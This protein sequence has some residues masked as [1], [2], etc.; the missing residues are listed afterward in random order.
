MDSKQQEKAADLSSNMR[1]IYV[2]KYQEAQDAYF[3]S[4][5][6]TPY[7]SSVYHGLISR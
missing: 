1:E 2:E 6:L 4:H 5:V 7:L 3:I